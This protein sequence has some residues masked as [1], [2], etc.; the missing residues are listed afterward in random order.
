M[1]KNNPNRTIEGISA[2]FASAVFLGFIPIFGKKAI[3]FGFSPLCIVAFRTTFAAILLCLLMIIT[4]RK[5]FYIYSLGLIGCL[6]AG[7]INGVG[8]IFYYTALTKLDASV[9]HLVYSSYPLFVALW[10]LF[11]KISIKRLTIIRILL[12]IPGVFLL[13]NNGDSSA[14]LSGAGAM[15]ISAALYALHL[16]INQRVLYEV[17]APTVT[18]YTLLSMSATVVIAFLLFDFNFPVENTPWWPIFGMA[19]ITFASRLT[20]F[21]GVK[22]LG[23]MQTALLGLGELLVTILIAWLWLGESLSTLQAIGATILGISILLIGFEKNEPQK[24]RT[25]GW[26]AWL[27]PPKIQIEDIWGSNH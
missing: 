8:S 22:K 23:S 10:Q 12:Y 6:L 3:L 2:A 25:T 4:Q 26:L 11:D 18:L 5:Y 17:P 7:F 14:T 24:R 13:L 1:K 20:L 19:A 15:A 16:I 9:G 27:N 21:M